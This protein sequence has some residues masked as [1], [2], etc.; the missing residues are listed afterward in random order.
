MDMLVPRASGR[1]K[2]ESNLNRIGMRP[3]HPG[4]ILKEEFLE[5]LGITAAGLASSLNEVA[6]EVSAL[7]M[8]ERG[9][10]PDLAER[11]S[12]YLHTTPEFWLN[13]QSTY[14]QRRAEIERG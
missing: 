10:G 7:M 13:L 4:E 12:I 2:S 3:I 9:V 5:P 11:L 1:L 6:G 14:D 8:Q